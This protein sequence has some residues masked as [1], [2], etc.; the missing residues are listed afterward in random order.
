M[1]SESTSP[2]YF[3]QLRFFF[4]QI[5]K[6]QSYICL[7]FYNCGFVHHFSLPLWGFK[8]QFQVTYRSLFYFSH[9]QQWP[10]TAAQR[11]ALHIWVFHSFPIFHTCGFLS[12]LSCPPT[13]AAPL[14]AAAL[15]TLD[16][17]LQLLAFSSAGSRRKSAGQRSLLVNRLARTQAAW[18][19]V[20]R[21]LPIFTV[22]SLSKSSLPSRLWNLIPWYPLQNRKD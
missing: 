5:K 21:L 4:W 9:W 22:C 18:H 2:L 1:W 11:L 13:S 7:R 16:A 6:V 3:A 17:L 12:P 14:Q 8:I 15:L 20:R 10:L 19:W